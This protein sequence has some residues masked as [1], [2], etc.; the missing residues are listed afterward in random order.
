MNVEVCDGVMYV[1]IEHSPLSGGQQVYPR[2][3]LVN[4]KYDA[5]EKLVECHRYARN[6]T[7]ISI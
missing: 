1:H 4:V 2:K 7:F 3:Y 6:I 5:A